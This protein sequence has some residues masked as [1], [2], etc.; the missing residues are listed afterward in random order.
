MQQNANRSALRFFEV[1]LAP[2]TVSLAAGCQLVSMTR[3]L[4]SAADFGCITARAA[5]GQ[6][7]ATMPVAP[8]G[9]AQ[10]DRLGAACSK[11]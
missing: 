1:K 7:C 6:D 2:N 10:F 3:L 8:A 4:T 5:A 9:A 11:S